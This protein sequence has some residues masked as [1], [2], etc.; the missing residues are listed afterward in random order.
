MGQLVATK[1]YSIIQSLNGTQYLL[2]QLHCA[3][4]DDTDIAKRIGTT[5]MTIYRWKRGVSHPR[6]A[7]IINTALA[8]LLKELEN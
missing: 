8:S 5:R 7:G 3:G 2:D 4:V 6:P 1:P